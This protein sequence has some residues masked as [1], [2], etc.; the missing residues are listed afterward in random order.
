MGDVIYDLNLENEALM[1]RLSER[2]LGYLKSE[3]N[4]IKKN[5]TISDKHKR[6]LSRLKRQEVKMIK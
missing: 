6:I 1:K 4:T 2:N 3:V 5:H